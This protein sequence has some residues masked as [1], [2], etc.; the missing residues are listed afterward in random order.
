MSSMFQQGGLL[1][2]T[3]REL[4]R[5]L[6]LLYEVSGHLL[7]LKTLHWYHASLRYADWLNDEDTNQYLEARLV[8][9][10]LTTVARRIRSDFRS[11]DTI[12]VGIFAEGT[13]MHLGNIR[14]SKIS[15]VHSTAE[16]GFVLGEKA[17]RGK[18]I[19]T[20]SLNTFLNFAVGVLKLEKI[21]AGCYETNTASRGTLE[22]AGFVL[23]GIE[24]N[25]VVSREKCR[26]SVLRFGFF[27]SPFT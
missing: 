2:N 22:R 10:S 25:Q 7:T 4:K 9:H 16:L 21:T 19:M 8:K 18:G 24:R 13:K 27:A 3:R 14:L 5:K 15:E 6:C 20:E 12:L 26:V 17:W 23:E 1:S 11:Q